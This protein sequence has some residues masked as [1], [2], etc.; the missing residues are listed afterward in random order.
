L[1]QLLRG[2]SE[3]KALGYGHFGGGVLHGGWWGGC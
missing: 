1:W 3:A 2:D